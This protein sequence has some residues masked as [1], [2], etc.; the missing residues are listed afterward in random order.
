MSE[1]KLSKL[2]TNPP[3]G[4]DKDAT[5]AKTKILIDEI[6]QLQ[7]V[8]IA[9]EAKSLLVIIQ[10]LDASGKDGVTKNVF[11]FL[12][13]MGLTVAAFKKPTPFEMAHDFL[14]RV[15]QVVPK[16]G[17]IGIF[18]R[19]HYEDVL[20]QRVHKWIDHKTV[21]QRFDHI[22]NFEMLLEQSGTTIL[23]F[24]MHVSPAVQLER[25]EERRLNPEK[26][27]KHKDQDWEERK[28][29]KQYINAYEDIF[30][31][32]SKAAPWYIIPTDSNWYK[33]FLVAQKVRDTLISMKLTYPKLITE[34]TR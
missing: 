21:K 22:N 20:I 18:N 24:Y 13:P 34:Q 5:K 12:N 32:C 15:H 11:G 16:K 6:C 2:S 25:L 28:L 3:K 4:L 8:L 33:E 26:M 7:D 10:G 31:H 14:W 1:I 19:S 23:K 17:S 27:W 30:K 29:W 9:S